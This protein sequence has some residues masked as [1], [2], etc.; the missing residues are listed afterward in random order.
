MSNQAITWAFDQDMRA[1]PKAK[2][3]L[4][5]LANHADHKDGYCFL[6]ISTIAEETSLAERSVFRYIAALVRNGYLRK[7]RRKGGDGKQ[8]ANDYWI[9][10]NREDRAWSWGGE[11]PEQ[12]ESEPPETHGSEETDPLD[13]DSGNPDKNDGL[14]TV[15]VGE[16]VNCV[17]HDTAEMPK[18]AAG[19]TAI[20]GSTRESLEPTESNLKSDAASLQKRAPR[21]YQPPPPAMPDPQGS[22]TSGP[23]IFVYVGSRAYEAWSRV[24]A[25]KAGLTRWTLATERIVDGKLQRG[26]FFPTLFPPDEKPPPAGTQL[27]TEKDLREFGQTG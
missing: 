9:L 11:E 14:P 18:V 17:S 24:M 27:A 21:G 25:R 6:R 20:G 19:P 26:W 13:I 3:V 16:T 7:E 12:A 8:R 15:A 23:L 10:F 1:A 4:L 22:T 2:F 5:A